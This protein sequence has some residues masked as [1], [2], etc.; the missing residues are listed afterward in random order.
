MS[1]IAIIVPTVNR[2]HLLAG[3]V[4]SI[5]NSTQASHDTYFMV[6]QTDHQT[7]KALNDLGTAGQLGEY[8]SYTAAANAGVQ[9][10]SEPYFIVANDDVL[11]RFGWDA[12]ALGYMRDPIRVV[13]INQGDGRTSSFFLVDRRYIL[14]R[15][16]VPDEPRR[17]YHHGYRSQYCDTEFVGVAQARGVWA[18]AP[19][20]LVEHC[21]WTFGKAGID[22]NYQKALDSHWHDH[23]LYHQRR[24]LWAA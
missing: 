11:F 16:G 12:I 22:E 14:E 8:G 18:D 13:G 17:L 21:H 1:D 19:D 9:R 10:T 20:A 4:G 7:Q 6:E 5:R 24:R 23:N 3:L 2:P 15:S